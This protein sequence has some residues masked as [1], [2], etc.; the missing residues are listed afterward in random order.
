MS[1]AERCPQTVFRDYLPPMIANLE[2]KQRLHEACL[3]VI[4]SRIHEISQ[5]LA[6][7]REAS[8]QETKSSAG[9]K[10]ETG[11]EMMRIQSDMRAVQ[12]GEAQ[13][14][15]S[16]LERLD[17]TCLHEKVRTGSVVRTSNGTY[18]LAQSI[19]KVAIDGMEIQTISLASPLGKALKGLSAGQSAT[20]RDQTLEILSVL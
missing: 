15:L 13:V 9:D 7:A 1:R 18:F 5:A 6:E 14:L 4:R 2:T 12:L 10:Y 17:M 20:F 19:G 3:A 16:L 8:F 11:R